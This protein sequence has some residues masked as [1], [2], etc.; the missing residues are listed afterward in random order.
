MV[1]LCSDWKKYVNVQSTQKKITMHFH[2]DRVRTSI[3]FWEIIPYGNKA[4]TD[5]DVIVCDCVIDE[6]HNC[7]KGSISY[8]ECLQKRLWFIPVKMWNLWMFDEL[9]FTA[10]FFMTKPLYTGK[11][12]NLNS[13]NSPDNGNLWWHFFSWNVFCV[14]KFI[15]YTDLCARNRIIIINDDVNSMFYIWERTYALIWWYKPNCEAMN[16]KICYPSEYMSS[17]KW[18]YNSLENSI[19]RYMHNTCL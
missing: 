9:I 19:F 11:I 13:H 5:C 3:I 14:R 18:V 6:R 1:K 10:D 17:R 12:K 7:S 15:Y 4:H 2:Y 8:R 16:K